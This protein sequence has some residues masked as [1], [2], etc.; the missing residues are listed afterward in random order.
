MTRAVGLY[1][2]PRKRYPPTTTYLLRNLSKL[3]KKESKI[4]KHKI[5]ST[6]ESFDLSRQSGSDFQRKVEENYIH[7]RS[8]LSYMQ[9]D[10]YYKCCKWISR[11]YFKIGLPDLN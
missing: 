3:I 1:E 11:Y 4:I 2:S 6:N 8:Q 5:L 7:A 10:S 9:M